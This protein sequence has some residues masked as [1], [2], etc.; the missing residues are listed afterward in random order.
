MGSARTRGNVAVPS[1][2]QLSYLVGGREAQIV[3]SLGYANKRMVDMH[4]CWWREEIDKQTRDALAAAGHRHC[5]LDNHVRSGLGLQFVTV[6]Q[7]L[8][9]AREWV[10]K[11]IIPNQDDYPQMPTSRRRRV[12]AKDKR[13]QKVWRW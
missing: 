12:L 11:G 4:L 7:A 6:E 1:S 13:P 2:Y 9:A 5:S 10:A 3:Q 8:Q